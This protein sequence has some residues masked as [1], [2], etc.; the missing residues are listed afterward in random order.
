V[1]SAL[2]NVVRTVYRLVSRV[3]VERW[4]GSLH[5]GAIVRGLYLSWTLG[6]LLKAATGMTLDAGCGRMAQFACLLARRLPAWRLLAV[7]L[8]LVRPESPP[9]NLRLVIGDLRGLPV[10]GPFQAIYCLDVLEHLENVEA[11]LS[12]LA[13]CLAPG[14]YFLIHVPSTSQRHFLPGVDHEYSWLGPGEPGDAHVR[15]G[16][17]LAELDPWLRKAGCQ[18]LLARFTFGRAVSILQEIFMLGEARRIPGVG[19]A[20]VPLVVLATW[21]ERHF[22]GRSG[23]GLLVLARRMDTPRA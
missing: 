2:G 22:G 20:L 16:L 23:N 10:S 12:D 6:P 18:V 4:V 11:C 13:R 17:E 1:T 7:D 3:V 5:A 21:L 19:L 9:P 14:G 15:E 8:R